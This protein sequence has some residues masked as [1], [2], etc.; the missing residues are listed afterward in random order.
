MANRK[1][2]RE[3]EKTIWFF[4]DIYQKFVKDLWNWF[5]LNKD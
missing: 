4:P 2:L 1:G 5:I 3:S